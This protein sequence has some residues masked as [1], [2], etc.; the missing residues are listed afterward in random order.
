M[1]VSGASAVVTYIHTHALKQAT[2]DFV[3]GAAPDVLESALQT[4]TLS[5]VRRRIWRR[6]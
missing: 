1:W 6:V 2:S 5:A 3:G 4:P